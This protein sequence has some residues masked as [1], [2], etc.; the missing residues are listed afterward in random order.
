MLQT[1]AHILPVIG[2]N[3]PLVAVHKRCIARRAHMPGKPR[4]FPSTDWT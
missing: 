2:I 3:L 1:R 4:I